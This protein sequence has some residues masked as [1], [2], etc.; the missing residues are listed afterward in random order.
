MIKTGKYDVCIHLR[1]A[2]YKSAFEQS[3]CPSFG[4]RCACRIGEEDESPTCDPPAGT[5]CQRQLPR[6]RSA[7]RM[8]TQLLLLFLSSNNIRNV[9]EKRLNFAELSALEQVGLLLYN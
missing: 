5:P 8:S 7:G 4:G 2:C 3:F 1:Y 6:A 9:L